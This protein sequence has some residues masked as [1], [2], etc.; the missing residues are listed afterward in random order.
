MSVKVCSLTF[1]DLGTG[2]TA[3]VTS[4]IYQLRKEQAAGTI[5][6]FTFVSLNGM[7]MRHPFDTYVRLWEAVSPHKEKLNR[8]KRQNRTELAGPTESTEPNRSDR[9]AANRNDRATEPKRPTGPGHTKLTEPNRN[10][11]TRPNRTDRNEPNRP[12]RT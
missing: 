1:N 3:S 4:I 11:P 8:P 6:E 10:D 9:T 5:P 12:T 2:K 7:E